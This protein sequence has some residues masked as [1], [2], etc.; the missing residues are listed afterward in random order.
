MQLGNHEQETQK[1]DVIS[2]SP[3]AAP[4]PNDPWQTS[5]PRSARPT[6]S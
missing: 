5:I 3:L 4:D 2:P 1:L 6:S